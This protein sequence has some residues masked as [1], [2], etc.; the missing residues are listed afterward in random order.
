MKMTSPPMIPRTGLEQDP[1]SAAARHMCQAGV[2]KG[3]QRRGP[4]CDLA[5]GSNVISRCRSRFFIRG[6][7]YKV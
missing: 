6:Y 3:L 5:M 7:A 4:Q 1:D 2:R